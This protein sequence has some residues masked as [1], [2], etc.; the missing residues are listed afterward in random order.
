MTARSPW[1]GFYQV[2]PPL[3][4]AAHTTQFASPGHVIL[5]NSTGGSGLLEGGGSYVSY[6]DAATGD[7]SIVLE[8]VQPG[9]AG[10]GFSGVYHY[11]TTNETVPFVV[12]GGKSSG[13]SK[14]AVWKSNFVRLFWGHSEG[15]FR[16][17]GVVLS[18]SGFVSFGRLVSPSMSPTS[19]PCA[20][21]PEG[22]H[23]LVGLRPLK[24][25][26]H[27]VCGAP[28]RHCFAASL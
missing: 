13:I 14:L 23:N 15:W 5:A 27:G 21:E 9:M 6:Y 26:G 8:K 1:S 11:T 12:T 4:A 10:C 28:C 20:R 25:T 19:P 16:W 17:R 7:L 2:Q 3:W 18:A 24:E 22:N